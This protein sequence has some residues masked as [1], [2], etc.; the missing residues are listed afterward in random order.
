[1]AFHVICT[2]VRSFQF[3]ILFIFEAFWECLVR[4]FS[5]RTNIMRT[6]WQIV[7]NMGNREKKSNNT[8]VKKYKRIPTSE[9]KKRKNNIIRV[10]HTSWLDHVLFLCVTL[11]CVSVLCVCFFSCF[12]CETSK[13][14][15]ER[16]TQKENIASSVL[17]AG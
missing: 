2:L 16:V 6:N 9:K 5:I 4:I 8:F 13:T 3:R 12:I 11:R 17:N 1:M 14:K 10:V 7:R 15:V